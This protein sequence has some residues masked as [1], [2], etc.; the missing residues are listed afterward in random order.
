MAAKHVA[1]TLRYKPIS[2]ALS[3]IRSLN[4]LH[5]PVSFLARMRTRVGVESDTHPRLAVLVDDPEYGQRLELDR[6]VLPKNGLRNR[7]PVPKRNPSSG[8]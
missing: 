5:A 7:S 1:H 3:F 8:R 6:S 2:V 4:T